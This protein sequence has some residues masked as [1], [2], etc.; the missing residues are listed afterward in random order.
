RTAG[1]TSLA[2]ASTVSPH[3]F[4]SVDLPLAQEIADEALDQRGVDRHGV[5][6]SLKKRRDLLLRRSMR[7]ALGEAT[8]TG[9]TLEIPV[10]IENVAGGHR[11]PAGFSQ[12]REIWVHLSV[13]DGQGRVLYEVGR[14][15]R[16]DEDLRDKVFLRV[17]TDPDAVDFQGRPVGLFGADVR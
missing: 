6:L 15:D 3:Y 5:P 17:N 13:E 2:V 8:R 10:E 14:V 9:N 11:I 1:H 16:N 12:E 4:T 7:L